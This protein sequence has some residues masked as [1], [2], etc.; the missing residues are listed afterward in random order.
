MSFFIKIVISA[1]LIAGI[2][3]LGKRYTPV[4]AILAS[5]PITSILAFIW[6]Y[7]ETRNIEHVIDL[8][9]GIFW[10]VLP[11]L[12]FFIIFPFILKK[13]I[14]FAWAMFYSCLIMIVLYTLYLYLLG[15][16][17]IKI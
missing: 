2:S 4:A 16:L 7:K 11:S 17:G 1:L 8:S 10:M 3:E 13:G 12:L 9:Y 6:L 15:K 5:L 14:S